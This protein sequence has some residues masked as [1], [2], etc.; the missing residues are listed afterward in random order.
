M[1]KVQ[2]ITRTF[3]ES[4][5]EE[6][7]INLNN[8]YDFYQNLSNHLGSIFRTGISDL[9]SNSFLDEVVIKNP[10]IVLAVKKHIEIILLDKAE[11]IIEAGHNAQKQFAKNVLSGLTEEK[12]VCIN[13]F[14]KICNNAEEHWKVTVQLKCS[15]H[16]HN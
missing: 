4:I 1:V 11:L 14:D 7:K 13:I 6:L 15:R 5:S 8:D 10:D 9:Q 12:Q 2:L 3:I 16:I